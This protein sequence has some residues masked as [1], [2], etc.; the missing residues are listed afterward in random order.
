MSQESEEGMCPYLGRS[1]T[2]KSRK[3][4]EA[5]VFEGKRA[6]GKIGGLTKSMKG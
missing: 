1:L 5:I 3:S 2:C 4:A 6:N